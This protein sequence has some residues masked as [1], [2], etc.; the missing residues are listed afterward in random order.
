[1]KDLRRNKLHCPSPL[2]TM[3]GVAACKVFP[4]GKVTHNFWI[5]PGLWLQNITHNIAQGQEAMSSVGW[6]HHSMWSFGSQKFNLGTERVINL[7]INLD[8]SVFYQMDKVYG[9]QNLTFSA[10][11]IC[12]PCQGSPEVPLPW[13]S[14][15]RWLQLIFMQISAG[16]AGSGEEK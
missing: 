10:I 8:K 15:S 11:S 9:W 7:A 12:C 4:A 5:F 1:M 2:W 16:D 13:G 3:W 6:L 14:T